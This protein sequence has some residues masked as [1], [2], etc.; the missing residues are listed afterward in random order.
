MHVN[1]KSTS[2]TKLNIHVHLLISCV[3]SVCVVKRSNYCSVVFG[4]IKISVF[5]GLT[6]DKIT[7]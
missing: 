4:I 1:I 2:T 7:V 3:H 5:F 6:A